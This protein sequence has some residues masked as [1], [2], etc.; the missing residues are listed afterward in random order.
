MDTILDAP[1]HSVVK[2]SLIH[3]RCLYLVM[4]SLPAEGFLGRP[5]ETF[6]EFYHYVHSARKKPTLEAE[7]RARGSLRTSYFLS[8]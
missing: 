3:G 6:F 4:L 7:H 2:E 5:H 8:T 1:S